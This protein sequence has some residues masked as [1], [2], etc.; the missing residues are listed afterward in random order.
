MTGYTSGAVSERA[1]EDVWAGPMPTLKDIRAAAGR[2]SGRAERT[3]LIR[4][5]TLSEIAQSEVR[6]KPECFQP[7]GAFKIRGAL[8]AIMQVSPCAREAGVVCASTGNHGRAVAYGAARLGVRAVVCLSRLVPRNKVDAISRLGGEVRIVG[9]SQD[10]A[11]REV[12]RLVREEGLTEIPPF[13]HRDVIAGQGTIGLEIVEDWPDV[14]TVV[15]PLSGGGLVSGVAIAAKACKADVRIVAVGA[16]RSAAMAESLKAE[17]PVVVEEVC[18]LADS[19][20]GG[21]GDANRYT[22][23]AVRRWVDTVILL[24]EREIAAAMTHLAFSEGLVV[25]GAGAVPVGAL[26]A[27]RL[28]KGRRTALVISGRNVD[29]QTFCAAVSGS[30]L[31]AREGA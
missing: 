4:S 29:A 23:A 18:G 15:V 25:E 8:N 31:P 13:D 16:E 11:Q 9:R 30:H 2:I 26:L 1:R 10:D 20:G 22:L 5:S 12:S 21:I 14:E 24:D 19:L 7:T 6:L 28:A 27:G 17:R 3:A